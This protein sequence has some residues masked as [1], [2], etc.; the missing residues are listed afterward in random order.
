MFSDRRA[1]ENSP[2]P[3]TSCDSRSSSGFGSSFALENACLG[4]TDVVAVRDE[5]RISRQR[6]CERLPERQ[7]T[8]RLVDLA[9]RTGGA[10]RCAGYDQDK[11]SF[12]KDVH[13]WA[14]ISAAQHCTKM[15][16]TGAGCTAEK[17]RLRTKSR[18]QGTKVPVRRYEL[19]GMINRRSHADSGLIIRERHRDAD[20]NAVKRNRHSIRWHGGAIVNRATARRT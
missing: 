15:K 12:Q 13:G 3:T 11:G 17:G 14:G 18:H 4:N 20:P 8:R 5:F 9:G 2:L 16:P 1:F 10:D 7:G 19:R 6:Q